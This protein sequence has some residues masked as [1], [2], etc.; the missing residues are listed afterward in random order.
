MPSFRRPIF[1]PALCLPWT[2]PAWLCLILLGTPVLR[3]TGIARTHEP[4]HPFTEVGRI[5]WPTGEKTDGVEIKG[6]SSISYDAQKN[7]FYALSDR[8]GPGQA[9]LFRIAL[10]QEDDPWSA[11]IEPGPS[12]RRGDGTVFPSLDAEGLALAPCGEFFYVSTEG[13]PGHTDP[14]IRLPWVAQFDR[15]ETTLRRSLPLPEDF[16]PRNAAGRLVDPGAPDQV[17][18]VQR[19]LGFE[20]LGLTPSGGTLYAANEAALRQDDPR[21]FDFSLRQAEGSV[22]RIIR[23]EGLP[24]ESRLT[25][26]RAYQT[27][28]G[29]SFL[30]MRLF[31]TVSALEPEGEE[32]IL[33]VLERGVTGTRLATGFFRLR[34]Y[35]VDFNEAEATALEEGVPIDREKVRPLT[36]TLV[37]ESDKAM[38]NGEGLTRGPIMDGRRTFAIVSDNNRNRAQETQLL[39]LQERSAETAPEK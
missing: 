11:T 4:L 12:L 33:Y 7:V 27:D 16:L 9:R 10:N 20:A 18:G 19:N 8:K 17:Y 34:L 37:W 15:N 1:L 13:L 2:F 38:D 23:W 36:K 25:G 3:S 14:L 30:R 6:L 28:R 21:V 22:I 26:M 5:V 35:R 24:H 29:E 39:I 32:G 31:H